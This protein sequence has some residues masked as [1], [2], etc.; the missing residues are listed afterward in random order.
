MVTKQQQLE[1][2]AAKWTIWHH[3]M[4]KI[5]MSIT[6]IGD[7]VRMTNNAHQI[8][9]EEWQQERN[10]M[11]AKPEVDNSWFTNGGFP[12]AGT[13]CEVYENEWVET[14]IIGMDKEG[15]CVYTTGNQYVG[16]DGENNPSNFRPI[17]T[18]REKAIGEMANLIAKSVFG[19]AKCQAEKLYDAGYRKVEPQPSHI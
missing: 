6:A 3:P 12:P 4:G 14:F 7:F 11:K 9:R 16:Y 15:Y 13:V 5:F 1:W 17:R 18:E 2:L 19:S 10:K 8:T